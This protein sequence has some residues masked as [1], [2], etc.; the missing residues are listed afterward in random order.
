RCGDGC[1]MA[2]SDTSLYTKNVSRQSSQDA[3]LHG[4]TGL[5]TRTSQCVVGYSTRHGAVGVA[6]CWR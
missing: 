6:G 4:P 3:G 5:G 1:V 2:T